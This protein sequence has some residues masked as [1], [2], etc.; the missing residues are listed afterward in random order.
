MN[1]GKIIQVMGPVVDVV[2]ENGELP[3]IKDALVVDNDGKKCVMEVSQHVGNDTVRCIMLS[4]SEGLSRDMEV[5]LQE[6]ESRFQSEIRHSD[7]SLM[8]WAIRLTTENR[9]KG[10]SIGRFTEIR[11]LLKS[12]AR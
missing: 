4:A 5:T 11:R 3:S 9:W 12:R 7:A 2:F 6:P 1:K 8:S 10:R